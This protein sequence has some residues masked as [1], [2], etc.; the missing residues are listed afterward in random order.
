LTN[1]RRV[2]SSERFL[3][4][5]K[6]GPFWGKFWA[7]FGAKTRIFWQIMKKYICRISKSLNSSYFQA[8]FENL[9]L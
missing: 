1:E 7:I 2:S 4:K 5:G 6:I 8:V 3:K 9:I